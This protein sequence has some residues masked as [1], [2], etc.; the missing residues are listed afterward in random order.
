MSPFTRHLVQAAMDPASSR[1]RHPARRALT[2]Y[3]GLLVPHSG[4]T[5]GMRFV[6]LTSYE[7]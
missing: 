5:S 2:D 3:L 6:T 1:R 4:Q 7:E